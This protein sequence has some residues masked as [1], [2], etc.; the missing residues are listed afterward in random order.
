MLIE[1]G[2]YVIN[3]SMVT[4]IEKTDDGG[5]VHF[6]YA[7]E[8]LSEDEYHLLRYIIDRQYER[9]TKPTT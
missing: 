4:Y 2:K 5:W 1:I 3:M 6:P 7:K 9:P 8:K